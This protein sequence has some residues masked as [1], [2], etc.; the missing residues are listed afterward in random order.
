[1]VLSNCSAPHGN[2]VQKPNK[3]IL[4]SRESCLKE[5]PDVSPGKTGLCQPAADC[6]CAVPPG[7]SIAPGSRRPGCEPPL[8]STIHNECRH[9]V[10]I[11]IIIIGYNIRH[12]S[13]QSKKDLYLG[14]LK[15]RRIDSCRYSILPL[16]LKYSPETEL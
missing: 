12:Q 9:N 4:L 14:S 11:F 15:H 10:S 1:M 6:W 2:P 3:V 13:F 16:L 8:Y 5:Q 7:Q